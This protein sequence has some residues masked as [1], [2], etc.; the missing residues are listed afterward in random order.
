MDPDHYWHDPTGRTLHMFMRAHTGGT[1]YACMAKVVEM[2]DGTMKTMLETVPSGKKNGVSTHAG[3][4]D[5]ISPIYMMNQ[6][7][8]IGC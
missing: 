7:N 4:S 2:T 3:R 1:G 6:P 5:E 8:Y